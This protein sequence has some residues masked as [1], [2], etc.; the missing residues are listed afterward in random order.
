M[1]SSEGFSKKQVELVEAIIKFGTIK[2]AAKSLNISYSSAKQR[3]YRL[4]CTYQN[5][6]DD[7]NYLEKI[8]F[9]EILSKIPACQTCKFLKLNGKCR[10]S[11]SK[12]DVNSLD[13]PC[14]YWQQGELEGSYSN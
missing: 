11:D 13:T 4:R 3:M 1:N 10:H 9:Y 7:L 8:N 6:V 12:I 2:K 5:A 14:I